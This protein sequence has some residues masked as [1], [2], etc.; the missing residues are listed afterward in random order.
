[1]HPTTQRRSTKCNSRAYE[2]LQRY[3]CVAGTARLIHSSS[4]PSRP[5][6]RRESALSRSALSLQCEKRNCRRPGRNPLCP[7]SNLHSCGELDAASHV[8]C[9]S[10]NDKSRPQ[11]GSLSQ[12]KNSSQM[13]HPDT[14][15]FLSSECQW[16]S[17]CR[18]SKQ[19]SSSG[20]ARCG[21]GD[22]I[23]ATS[24]RI[25]AVGDT[26]QG[27]LARTV[28]GSIPSTA[29][30]TQQTQDHAHDHVSHERSRSPLMRRAS[31]SPRFQR[32]RRAVLD[33]GPRS[34]ADPESRVPERLI[35]R[36]GVGL[37]GQCDSPGRSFRVP[38]PYDRPGPLL[39]HHH[40]QF[41]I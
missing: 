13:G 28:C 12:A 27:A 10:R 5:K 34:P 35:R 38:S 15:S 17:T 6:S 30:Q 11:T 40:N 41:E 7:S 23:P 24:F 19:N 8:Q 37:Q 33:L 18:S 16:I 39:E 1:M 32:A 3:S 29:E 31:I 20:K 25:H 26:L 21:V 36:M 14:R 2:R 4:A 22:L 9:M